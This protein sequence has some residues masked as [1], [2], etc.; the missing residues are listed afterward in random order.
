[1]ARLQRAALGTRDGEHILQKV[2]EE[3]RII[4][5]TQDASES[6][7]YAARRDAALAHVH[8]SADWYREALFVDYRDK[9]KP[10]LNTDAVGEI[11]DLTAEY[12]NTSPLLATLDELA[13]SLP[14]YVRDGVLEAGRI[15]RIMILDEK[16]AQGSED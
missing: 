4:P 14:D 5:T 3:T 8:K 9:K 2:L 6:G 1:M 13:H 16:L 7:D 12:D 10:G 15:A 11:F